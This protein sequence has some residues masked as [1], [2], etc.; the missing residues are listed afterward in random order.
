VIV[1]QLQWAGFLRL[2]SSNFRIAGTIPE[3]GDR[4][5]PGFALRS[6]RLK[7]LRLEH[8]QRHQQLALEHQKGAIPVLA[9]TNQEFARLILPDPAVVAEQIAETQ[10]R[11]E[12]FRLHRPERFQTQHLVDQLLAHFRAE[13]LVPTLRLLNTANDEIQAFDSI[14]SKKP[15]SLFSLLNRRRPV[16]A[17]TA[18]QW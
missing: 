1:P 16:S 6:R 13:R 9:L 3:L 4:L 11:R 17:I 18:R 10:P 8:L 15:T 2:Q 14:L 5:K 7:R 12:R